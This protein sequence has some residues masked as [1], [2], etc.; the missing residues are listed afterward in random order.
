MP[1]SPP[2]PKREVGQKMRRDHGRVLAHGAGK[3]LA[4]STLL[5][6]AAVGVRG[7]GDYFPEGVTLRT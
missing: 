5:L 3:P 6:L 7:A 1:Q 4:I 2:P